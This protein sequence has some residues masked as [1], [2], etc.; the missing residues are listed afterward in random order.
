MME[1]TVDELETSP[2]RKRTDFLTV[3][4]ILT[5]VG[6]GASILFYGYQ[7]LFLGAIQREIGVSAGWAVLI[8][9]LNMI[10]PIFCVVGSVFMWNLKKQGFFIYLFGQLIP[11]L[12]SF[13]IALVVNN[14]KGPS[15]VFA[16]LANVIPMGFIVLY[17]LQLKDLRSK[18]VSEFE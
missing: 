18:P 8:S 1:D 9:I 14:I 7:L 10:A 15:L 3:L 17:G 5:W 16:I 12:V 11:I 13:Y 4:C 2:I 6:S